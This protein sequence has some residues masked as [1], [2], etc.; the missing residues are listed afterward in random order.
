MKF[1]NDPSIVELRFLTEQFGNN[2]A[3]IAGFFDVHRSSITRWLKGVDLP[4]PE[5]QMRIAA[6][7]LVLMRLSSVFNPSTGQKWLQGINAHLGNNRP[8]DLIKHGRISEVLA[9]IE[10]TDAGSYA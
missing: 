6:L 9:A 4:K 3:I 10:Q 8:I 2:Q 7:R 1:T 5:N